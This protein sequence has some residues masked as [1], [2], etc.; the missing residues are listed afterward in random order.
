MSVHFGNWNFDRHSN[1]A[2]DLRPLREHL[3]PYGPDGSGDFQDETT[4][5][6]FYRVRETE[7]TG[8]EEQPCRIGSHQVL[9]WDGRLDNRGDLLRELAGTVT[10]S[11]T[12]VAIVAAAYTRWDLACLPKLIGDWALSIWDSTRQQL[13]LAKDFLGTRSLF[14]F[15]DQTHAQWCTVLDPLVL[16]AGRKFTLNREYLAGW[17]GTFPDSRLTPYVGISA[18]PPSSYVLIRKGSIAVREFWRFSSKRLV[19]PNDVE[20]GEEFRQ[21]FSCPLH[22]DSARLTPCSLN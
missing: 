19:R 14:Y 12:D 15:V 7:E 20:Y 22:A 1:N 17:F 18:V 10:T 3:A 5:I 2:L 6:L 21:L 9:S 13:V 16:F 8:S 11:D 4:Q